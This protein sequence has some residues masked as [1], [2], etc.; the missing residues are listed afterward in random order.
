MRFAEVTYDNAEPVDGYGP[1]FFRIGSNRVEGNIL[2]L[3]TGV[4]PWD[5]YADVGA[6]T[7]AASLIDVLLVGTGADPAYLPAE[8]RQAIEG[9]GIGI[10][11]MTT[12]AACRTYNLLLG[13]GRRVGAALIAV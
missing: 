2:V 12:P 4:A 3:P 5:G 13:E 11:P 9:A 6:A 7:E 1:G 8:F 10:E